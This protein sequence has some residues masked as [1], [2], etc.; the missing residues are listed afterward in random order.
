MVLVVVFASVP[1]AFLCRTPAIFLV[2]P[3]VI[4]YDLTLSQ[5]ILSVETLLLNKDTRVSTWSQ[6]FNI[7]G[8]DLSTH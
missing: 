8:G 5:L 1:S 4:H 7:C 3:A 6:Y 2:K